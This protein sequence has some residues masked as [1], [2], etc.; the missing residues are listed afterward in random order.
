MQMEED[1][2]PIP[3]TFERIKKRIFTLWTNGARGYAETVFSSDPGT[4]KGRIEELEAWASMTFI[5][6][7][8]D[9]ERKLHSLP[10][11]DWTERAQIDCYWDHEALTSLLWA[12]RWLKDFPAWHVENVV[13]LDLFDFPNLEQWGHELVLIPPDEIETQAMI[14]E[15]CYWRLRSDSISPGP[16][17][18]EYGRKLMRKA[19]EFGH[20]KLATDGDLALTDGRS[21]KLLSDEE[22][23]LAV[24]CLM[25]RLQ[26]L[27]WL[28]GHEEDWDQVTIDTSVSWLW[29]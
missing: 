7:M 15:T 5:D 18:D 10:P 14:T 23:R 25:E 29:S 20:V 26:G 1:P 8:T 16:E 4:W 19:A 13:P 24:S 2:V 27:N 28:C 17:M 22:N 11:G 3:P 9:A 12:T 21:Y 6:E